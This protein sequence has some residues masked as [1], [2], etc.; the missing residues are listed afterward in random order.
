MLLARFSGISFIPVF[1]TKSIPVQWRV[2]FL[3]LLTFFAWLMG[4]AGDTT[5]HLQLPNYVLT[6]LMELFTGIALALIVQFLFAAIQLAGQIIDTQMGFGMMNVVDPLNGT[7]APLL[8]NFK[9]ILALLVFL[10]IDGHHQFILAVFDSYTTFPVGES[11]LLSPQ[12][13]QSFLDYFG[14]IFIIGCKLGMPIVG[15]LLI[16]DFILGIMS[17]TVPQMN[18]F[19]VGLQAKIIIGF[20]VLLATI[21]L[22]VYLLNAS[23]DDMFVRIYELIN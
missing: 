3:M 1:N 7:Q 12:F 6:L 15:A 13:M 11:F 10:E 18:I 2:G 23:F 16:T 22:L 21:P 9:Y 19:M 5:L 17:R 20:F 4:L 14:S 8:G